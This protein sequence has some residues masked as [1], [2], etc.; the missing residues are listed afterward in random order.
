[1]TFASGG[2]WLGLR[3]VTH[4]HPHRLSDGRE[5]AV[6]N[7]RFARDLDSP[8]DVLGVVVAIERRLL[9]ARG[10][11][12]HVEVQKPREPIAGAFAFHLEP[13]SVE[14]LMRQLPNPS[15]QANAIVVVLEH[16]SKA[17]DPVR[18]PPA[19]PNVAVGQAVSDEPVEAT[20]VL[21][22]EQ[23]P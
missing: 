9:P 6:S 17:V 15:P 14:R 1:L 11:L 5:P 10:A 20:S 16:A 22:R 2:L 4:R 8:L 3:H 12:G 21:D 19:I 18:R 13:E 23:Y 7:D